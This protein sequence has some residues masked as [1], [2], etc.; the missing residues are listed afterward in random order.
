MTTNFPNV[1]RVE[2]AEVAIAA[3]KRIGKYVVTFSGFSGNGYQDTNEVCKII[4][5]VLS[6][7]TP[8]TTLINA[9]GTTD[10]IGMVYSIA[11]RLGF[12]AIGIVS[13]LAE[14]KKAAM[15]PDAHKIYIVADDVWGGSLPDGTLSPTSSAM[16][17][18]SDEIIA[19][20]GDEIARDE[21]SVAMAQ[22]KPVRYFAAEMNHVL[23][24]R[25]AAEKGAPSPP[26]FKGAAYRLFA[27]A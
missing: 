16:V 10:G 6:K 14:A 18:A 11:K 20:G 15:S 1:L 2:T 5:D 17:G 9:G 4:E 3:V 27:P 23:A 13:S 7:L 21:L 8:S 25:K 24:R 22:G 12:T 19:I 26:D